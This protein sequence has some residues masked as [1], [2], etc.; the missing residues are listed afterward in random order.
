MLPILAQDE[1][2][3]A[4]VRSKLIISL[5]AMLVSDSQDDEAAAVAK[6]RTLELHMLLPKSTPKRLISPARTSPIFDFDIT[7]TVSASKL[8]NPVI[9]EVITETVAE[10]ARLFE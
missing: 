1:T 5:I 8:T 10:I 3:T 6:T 9:E 7:E 4:N 2:A